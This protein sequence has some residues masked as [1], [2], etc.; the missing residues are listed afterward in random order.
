MRNISLKT[1]S[2]RFIFM[3]LLFLIVTAGLATMVSIQNRN[4]SNTLST[5]QDVRIPVR[6]TSGNIIGSIDR[7][8]S[9]QRAYMLS[10]NVKFK[11]D[12]LKV[13]KHEIYPAIE[14]LNHLKNEL[15][16]EHT[17]VIGDIEAK[18][19]E[20]ERVQGEILNYFE[21]NALPP[22]RQ[23]EKATE[24]EWPQLTDVFIAKLKAERELS[25]QIKFANTLR[26]QLLQ[27]VTDLRN[28][29]E[30]QLT[31]EV[32]FVTN[33]MSRSKL[34]VVMS[35]VLIL[36]FL[37][38]FTII[39]I[40]SL[41][42]SIQKP[43]NLINTLA[44]G[45]LPDKIGESN[46]E[47]NEILNAGKKLTS[48]I[49]SASQ[50]AL[51]IGEG[52]LDK[53]YKEASDKDVLGKSLLHMR[54][55]LKEIALEEQRRNWATAGIA[56]LGNILRSTGDSEKLYLDVLSYLI[57]YVK[58]NQGALYLVDE[59][60]Q[61]TVLKL[62]SCY[63]YNKKKYIDQTIEPGQGLIGQAYLEKQPIFIKEVPKD[64][65][66]ITSGL[67]DAPPRSILISPLMLNDEVFGILE[68]A[69]FKEFEKYEQDFVKL[70][71]DQIAS[72]VASVKNNERTAILLKE[73][74]QQTEEMRSQEEEMRQNME[75]LSATQEEMGR[76]EK[77]Y[78]S[79]IQLLEEALSKE[80]IAR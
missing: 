38:G 65:V 11:E 30:R 3:A 56:E 71:A 78:M 52:D 46:D 24:E 67:G 77:E 80:T 63:A 15:N 12:R 43:V 48:N 8:M 20:F 6:L 26:D 14:T 29:Q 9:L 21:S 53:S 79:R 4:S 23:I 35:S 72:I 5:M 36:F 58:A 76:K 41:R 64:Y 75:E 17:R 61:Q 66:R 27:L 22:L 37:I 28:S 59:A 7:V 74:Q 54:D 60:N 55:R 68:M 2:G 39:T 33:S 40:R 25:D 49:Q 73:S 13:Y 42:K 44:S 69:T 1:I 10:G 57:K 70:A 50:F 16:E 47:L 62:V 51:A 18:V 32:S 34:I 45:E 31:D 19:K